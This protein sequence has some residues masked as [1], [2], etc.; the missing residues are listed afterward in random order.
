MGIGLKKLLCLKSAGLIEIGIHSA[1][2]N[3]AHFI[4]IGLSVP[5]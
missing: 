5:D 4:K 2:L 1:S 3:N